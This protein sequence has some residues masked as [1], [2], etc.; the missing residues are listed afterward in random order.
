MAAA[1]TPSG[2]WMQKIESLNKR[3]QRP[4]EAPE[5]KRERTK[6]RNRLNQCERAVGAMHLAIDALSLRER[7]LVANQVLRDCLD[8]ARRLDGNA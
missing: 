5:V 3:T 6:R 2:R 8:D 7:I 1:R 4:S